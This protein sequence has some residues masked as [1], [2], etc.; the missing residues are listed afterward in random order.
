MK[1][2]ILVAPNKKWSNYAH[3]VE[4]CGGI[5]VEEYDHNSIDTFDGLLLCG[6]NDIHPA[7][8]GQEVS[9]TGIEPICL[10]TINP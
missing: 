7:F 1:P 4:Y 8:Y 9:L 6:G 10:G 5:A 2:R 3:A